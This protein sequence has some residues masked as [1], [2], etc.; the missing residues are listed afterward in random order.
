MTKK[1]FSFKDRVKSFSYA[2]KGISK[3]IVNEHNARV[4]LTAAILACS[5]GFVLQISPIE[6]ISILVVIG[7]VILSEL[8]NTAIERLADFVESDWNDTIGE[9][10]DY[11]SGAVL[12][13]SIV[14]F[15]VGLIVF[16]PK[17]IS[18]IE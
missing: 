4:H 18:F 7:L 6:W 13:A 1:S 5:M 14:A 16:V 9:V 3:L 2:F 17:L 15:I 8:F 12:V 11:A 10:K